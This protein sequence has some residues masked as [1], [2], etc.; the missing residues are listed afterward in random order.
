MADRK[1]YQAMADAFIAE[2]VAAQFT[3]MGDGNMHW[4]TCLAGEHGVRTIHA[5][6]EH[7]AVAMAM[8]Y[9]RAADTVGVA[10][11]TTGPGFTQITTALTSAARNNV[12]IVVFTGDTSTVNRWHHQRFE[13]AQVAR[14]TG[15]HFVPVRSAERALDCVREAFLVARMEQRPVVLSVP[16]D[17]QGRICNQTEPYLTSSGMVPDLGPIMPDP[18][19]VADLVA[20]LSRAERPIFIAG[21]GALAAD[22]RDAIERL[23][24]RTGALL[25]TTLPARG[26]FDH[27][28]FSVGIAGGFASDLARE[29]FAQCDLVVAF[30]ASL[31]QY[32][33]DG[34]KLYPNAWV[35]QVDVR[36]RGLRDGLKTADL[37]V[38][39][40][41]RLTA[42][43]VLERMPAGRMASGMRSPE[44]AHAIA[45]FRDP[46][47]FHIEADTLDPREAIRALDA[48]LP[49]DWAIVSASGHSFYFSATHMRGRSPADFFC[50]KEF[51]EIGSH[52]ACAI[53]VAVARPDGRVA[54]IDGDGSLMM[55]IQ[56]LET[57]KRHGLRLLIIALN[58]GAFG[59]EVHK[60]RIQD[61]FPEQAEFGRPDYEAIAKGFGLRGATI[62]EGAQFAALFDRHLS[63]GTAEMWNVH[64][65]SNVVSPPYRRRHNIPARTS[66]PE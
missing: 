16:V 3:L 10:S 43:A 5:R 53:G 27:N 12:P 45:A 11:V 48:V 63:A 61:H 42:E 44:V 32:T 24:E 23:A 58:D 60:L 26:L 31:G 21:R 7:C 56:E 55:N 54:V 29:C 2:G 47:W 9:A 1:V 66:P 34:G 36:P 33:A 13:Q 8:G 52:L 30:G 62:S 59:A 39:G 64:I 57:V 6:H 22:A 35:A 65:S 17:L 15:A 49:K 4:V 51:G 41:S 25:S 19:A 37:H 28:P 18:A 20:R 38:A 40:D 50:F 14:A 46:A